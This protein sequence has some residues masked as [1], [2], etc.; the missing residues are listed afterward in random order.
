[1][2]EFDSFII[3]S[4]IFAFV[5][6]SVIYVAKGMEDD[7]RIRRKDWIIISIIV[8]FGFG[9]P[10]TYSILRCNY[11]KNRV[12]E[13]T[14]YEIKSLK[15][16]SV[17]FGRFYLGNGRIETKQYYFFYVEDEK[18]YR[19]EKVEVENTYINSLANSNYI[20][21]TLTEKKI[22]GETYPYYIIYLPQEYIVFDYN[23]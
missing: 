7:G 15:T 20:V 16:D 9:S 18:G 10:T 4:F 11:E 14:I 23:I 8:F 1:M 17:V 2:N 13:K 19:T 12:Y 21:P 5:I 6:T 3:I 22:K